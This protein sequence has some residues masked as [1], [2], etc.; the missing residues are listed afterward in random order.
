LGQTFDFE[1]MSVGAASAH[2][3]LTRMGRG[4]LSRGILP[5]VVAMQGGDE[6]AVQREWVRLAATEPEAWKRAEYAALALVFADAVG[7]RPSWKLALEELTVQDPPIIQEWAAHW[8]AR[9]EAR[10][11]VEGRVEMARANTALVLRERFGLTDLPAD[12]RPVLDAETNPD[13]LQQWFALALTA[14]TLDAFRAGLVSAN[15]LGHRPPPTPDV[16]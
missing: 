8:E 4:E 7:R 10:G 15:L 14:A 3:H 1:V 9:G 13:K 12:L 16:P 11:R 6:G 2:D 5:W